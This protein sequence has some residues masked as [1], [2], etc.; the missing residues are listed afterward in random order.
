MRFMGFFIGFIDTV[1]CNAILEILTTLYYTTR[2][3]AVVD[4]N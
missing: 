1:K 4:I 3:I 2:I